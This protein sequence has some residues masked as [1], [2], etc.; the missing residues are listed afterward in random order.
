MFRKK[1]NL[2]SKLKELL[3]QDRKSINSDSEKRKQ[4]S[5]NNRAN[6]DVC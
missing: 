5:E 1:E 2:K 6:K 3:E 4:K